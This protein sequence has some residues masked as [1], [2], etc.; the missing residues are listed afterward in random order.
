LQSGSPAIDAGTSPGTGA[1]QPLDP[2]FEYVHPACGEV[3]NLAGAID[4][5]AYEFGGAG[6]SLCSSPSA[7]FSVAINPSSLNLNAGATGTYTVT[8]SPV[9]GFNG[10]VTL[11]A[12]R[13]ICG[14]N[15]I[16]SDTMELTIPAPNAPEI[17]IASSTDGNA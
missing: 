4:I 7:D 15:T 6:A 12:T 10:V 9:N 1:L 3:R 5:G 17:A 13:V 16:V 2:T 8:V 11:S 14:T